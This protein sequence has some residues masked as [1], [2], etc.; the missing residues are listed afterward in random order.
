MTRPAGQRQRGQKPRTRVTPA[1]RLAFAVLE[2]IRT[3]KAWTDRVFEA[4]QARITIDD[5]DRSFARAM[6]YGVIQRRRTLDHVVGRAAQ[7]QLDQIDPS[8]LTVLRMGAWEVLDGAPGESRHAAVDQAVEL[9]RDAV[10]HRPAGFVNAVMR[11]LTRDAHKEVAQLLTN[12]SAG[13]LTARA[14][15][16]SLPDWLV[17]LVDAS[18]GERGLAA[19][20]SQHMPPAPAF[21]LTEL[22]RDLDCQS[23]ELTVPIAPYC[24]LLP[25]ARVASGPTRSL[26]PAIDAGHLVPQSLASQLVTMLL[27]PRP[28]ESVIDMCAAPGGK[29]IDIA[30]RVGA[31]GRV[32][33]VDLHQHRLDALAN[34][35]RRANVAERIELT[36]ADA[37]TLASGV[38]DRVLVDAPCTG[39]G[40]MARRPDARWNRTPEDLATLT[41]LQRA[42]LARAST[43]VAPGGT[44]VYATCSLLA[45]ENEIV[46]DSLIAEGTLER[47]ALPGSLAAVVDSAGHHGLQIDV[48]QARI[49]TWPGEGPTDGFTIHVLAR[50]HLSP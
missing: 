22:G 7:R 17:R 13:D 34:R 28:G 4:E 6:S 47:G 18:H 48:D 46:V 23:L 39:T 37:T 30:E 19:L 2:R 42:L 27:D 43:L 12:A 5:R 24:D 49:R 11:R 45:E 16:D 1:R 38:V 50:P 20:A 29:T 36:C 8:V 14:I 40:V 33:A 21:R 25:A 3:D 10:G 15:H 9:V 32:R 44:V 35:A 41:T 31:H 26:S